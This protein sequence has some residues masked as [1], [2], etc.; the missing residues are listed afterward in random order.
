MNGAL[1]YASR[2]GST[3]KYAE[4]IGESTG[5]PIF[6]VKKAEVNPASFDFL[7]FGCPVIYHKLYYKKWVQQNLN[8]ILTKPFILY[9]VSGAPAGPKLDGWIANSLP[10][11]VITH[12]Q[13]IALLG[14][15]NP[16][17]LSVFDRVML[18]IGGLMNPD[19]VASR[20]ERKGFEY[21]DESSIESINKLVENLQSINNITHT[22]QFRTSES[23]VTL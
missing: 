9:T 22:T 14:R 1:F 23:S 5:L 19:P 13:H 17:E 18:S 15:Q 6:D 7:V 2:Y 20:D 21:M 16:K 12:M 4:W 3:K 8:H 10:K 11:S